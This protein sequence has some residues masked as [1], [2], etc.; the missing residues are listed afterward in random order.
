M[1]STK[2]TSLVR[3]LR[4][5]LGRKATVAEEEGADAGFTLIELMVVLLIMAILMAIAIPTFLG[6]KN[7]ANDRSAQSNLTNAMTAAKA[8]YINSSSGYI[9]SGSVVAQMN[10][11]EP[12]FTFTAAATSSASTIS[13]A[14]FG[15]AGAPAVLIMAVRSPVYASG[16]STQYKCWYAEDN[17]NS[18]ADT[19]TSTGANSGAPAGLSYAYGLSTVGPPATCSAASGWPTSSTNWST[20]YPST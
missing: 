20:S 12:E 1:E 19:S 4:E 13:V 11:T 8:L 9:S 15:A 3:H 17:E 2:S 10:S 5:A 14:A 18:S 6:V 16:S 7:S